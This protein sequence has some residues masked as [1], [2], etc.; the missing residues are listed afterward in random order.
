[1]NLIDPLKFPNKRLQGKLV[2]EIVL[3]FLLNSGYKIHN[4]NWYFGHKELDL[5]VENEEYRVFVEVK[6]RIIAKEVMQNYSAFLNNILP[7]NKVNRT[8]KKTM[9]ECAMHYS[10]QN[11]TNK[12]TRFDIVAFVG[13][14]YGNRL[15]HFK[16]AFSLKAPQITSKK[17]GFHSNSNRKYFKKM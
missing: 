1:M 9:I 11:P 12:Q 16:D 5:V 7:E 2:E 17:I 15:I 13:T 8:K 14:Y 10:N 6:S 3:N 4:S